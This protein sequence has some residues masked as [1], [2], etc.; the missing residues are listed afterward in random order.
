MPIAETVIAGVAKQS[1]RWRSGYWI[2]SS[3][4]LLAM[5]KK[6]A[7]RPPFLFSH[8]MSSLAHMAPI[9]ATEIGA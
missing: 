7:R 9:V 5:T 6:A 2:A 4:E 3:Q 8:V 1:R